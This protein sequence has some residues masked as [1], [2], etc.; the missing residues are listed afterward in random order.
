[1]GAV[2]VDNLRVPQNASC[3]LNGTKVQGT[4]KVE[5][6]ASL[7]AGN[8]YV[9]GNIQ[10]EGAESVN[11]SGSSVGGNIQIKQDGVWFIQAPPCFWAWLFH[12]SERDRWRTGLGARIWCT[13][14]P[15]LHRLASD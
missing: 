1:M 8:V 4:I 5:T 9:I 10:A 3:K 6:G 14:Q 2:T 12:S 15:S 11:V 13:R 7:T